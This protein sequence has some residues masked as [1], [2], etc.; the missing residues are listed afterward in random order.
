M[1]SVDDR[2]V[3]MKF[4][5]AEF[6]RRVQDTIKSM[7]ELKKS[8][9]FSASKKNMDDLQNA[10]HNFSLGG[11]A[12][13][14]QGLAEKF[15]SLGII[16]FTILSN[17]TNKAVDAGIQI[18]KSLSLDQV[19]AGFQ[20]Y[21]LKLGSIQTIMAG[22][23]A[24]LDVVNQKLNEL[25]T[26]SDKTIYSF[27]D[28]TQNI[29][30]FT[31]AGVDLDTAVA[32]IQGVAN[33]AAV[34]GANSEEAS[35]A[36]YNF[37]QA[38]SK[39]YVQLVDWKSIELANMGTKEFK[40]Q[41]IDAAVAQGTLTKRGEEYVTAAGNVTSATKGFN[42]SLT[43]QWLTTD[44][45]NKTLGDY[46][47]AS[48]DIG[49]KA[50]AAAQD[51]KTFSQL[52]STVKEA[53]GSGWAQSFEILIGNFDE[54]KTLFTD[55][56]T[57]VSNFVGKNADARN[58]LLQGWKDLG[59]RALL[60][61][62]LKRAFKNLGEVLAPIKEAFREV[63][64]PM[65]AQRLMD[66]T[67]SFSDLVDKMKPSEGTIETIKGIF[68]GFFNALEI[69]WEIIKQ[70]VGFIGDLIGAITPDS[71]SGFVDFAKKFGDFFADL[72]TKLVDGEGI[73]QFFVDLLE[74]IKH[75]VEWIQ[76]LKDKIVDFFSADHSE[77]GDKIAGAFGRIGDRFE[78][79]KKIFKKIQELWAPVQ[80][81]FENVAE[82][83]GR[84]WDKV[85]E[86]FGDIGKKIAEAVSKGDFSEA[87]D[88]INT[89]LL[90]GIALLVTRFFKKGINIDFGGGFFASI[91]QSFSELTDVFQAMQTKLKAEALMKIAIAIGIL[92]ASVLTLSLIDSG[93]LTKAL[94]AMAVGFGQLMASLAILSKIDIKPKDALKFT[95]IAFGMTVMSGAILMLSLAA[96]S[97]ADLDWNE[98]A[99]GLVGVMALLGM[100]V[101]VVKL[102]E[103]NE[104]SLISAGIGMI[105]IAVAINILAGA[106]K[107]FS[108][109][110][111]AEM[112]QGM[113]GVATSLL[114]IAGAMHLMPDGLALQAV[115][116]LAISVS[117]L[118]I[119]SALKQFADMSWTEMASGFAALAGGLVLIAGGVQ[120]M[121]ASLPLIGLGLV[122]VGASLLLIAKA[123]KSMA[124][125]SWGEIAKGLVAMAGSLLILAVAANLMTEA[126]P[127]AIAIGIVAAAL[128]VL[129]GVIKTLSN[130]T[131]G[132][133][134]KG[135]AGI[136]LVLGALAIAALLIQPALP[137]L[138]L[139]GV[140]LIAIGAGFALFGLG[141]GLAAS[142]FAAFAE[143]S[144]AGS[145]AIVGALKAVGM[146][147]PAL[148]TGFAMGIIE[149]A[150]V[151]GAAAPSIVEALGKILSALLDKLIELVPQILELI[152]T[153]LSG[154]LDLLVEKVPEIVDAGLKIIVGL[155]EGIR[156]HIPEIVTVVGEI[157]TNFLDALATQIPAIVTAGVNLLTEFLGGI[158]DNIQSVVDAGVDILVKFIEGIG[159]NITDVATAAGDVIVEFIEA[160]GYNLFRITTAAVDTIVKFID[161]LDDNFFRVIDAGWD[162]II[163]L[164]NGIAD[165][166]DGNIGDLREAGKKLA[167]A[168]INGM[169]LGLAS[170]VGDVVNKAKEV[171]G[172][173]VGG[174][175]DV[176]HVGSPSRVMI[177]M[178]GWVVEGLA[179]GMN[180]P[181]AER[182]ATSMAEKVTTAISDTL[183]K[184]P[185]MLASMDSLNPTITPVLDLAQIKAA[186]AQ[187]GPILDP[188][189]IGSAAYNQAVLV[190][191]T[192]RSETEDQPVTTKEPSTVKF[193]QNIYAPE[194]LTT[195]DIYRQTRAQIAMAKEELAVL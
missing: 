104:A 181:A 63:F 116:L 93:A 153:L 100:V 77:A 186:A 165:S 178:G 52:M 84:T 173:I 87:L 152:G 65:T 36:M 109:M 59:G 166:I 68:L 42:D 113:V 161:G 124:G 81:V 57:A 146:A 123:M 60:I 46:A 61:D 37:A 55:I 126:I 131:W 128:Y 125:M 94:G 5:N 185:D 6:E 13:A 102:L 183:A 157:I 163:N 62:S 108:M 177:E 88:V 12:D 111:W 49:K 133:L 15:T 151:I 141:I 85:K 191:L 89:G 9:D 82:V 29:G 8:L 139:L 95:I 66:L 132:E 20:E 98:L 195:A 26:Y 72:K 16:G 162:L 135:I 119:S 187:I 71:A 10:G 145:E 73:K 25:N 129:A 112:A 31:N 83:I 190:S 75:P 170:G 120:L 140:A 4:D 47:D 150:K 2:V 74:A 118:L 168:I 44:V 17:L 179:I 90:G 58:Q 14:V 147:L 156:D 175:A 67:Q 137:A 192:T 103:G 45:L 34:S 121:P 164:I 21:E 40:Q 101:G 28:M 143:A 107:I 53:I 117:L 43:D 158:S 194:A 97:L 169:T 41:L 122:L 115:G 149:F 76:T 174:I 160:I 56:N 11:M 92:T 64:P 180:D 155:L 30:K 110:S 1:A 24:P 48:T 148:L 19:I 154:L 136:A 172:K 23:G 176:L 7:D 78:S 144:K 99:K 114:I 127:G 70:T 51:V 130:L 91:K 86:F 182:G 189:A 193:E 79:L 33:V 105:G 159:Q 27:A 106:V 96:K 167:G 142:G 38:L 134:L 39:G 18:A 22:T 3:A 138:L 171:A 188:G 69:G 54:A 32:S 80:N 50:F 35:R 184:L